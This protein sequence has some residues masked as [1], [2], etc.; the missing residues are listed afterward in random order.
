M[1]IENRLTVKYWH[2][3]AKTIRAKIQEA[4]ERDVVA[5]RGGKLFFMHI[6]KCAGSSFRYALD[7]AYQGCV[8]FDLQHGDVVEA[9][10]EYRDNNIGPDVSVQSL[11]FL[12][13]WKVFSKG[14]P[15]VYG[16]APFYDHIH[17]RFKSEYRFISLVRDPLEK[18]ISWFFY[19]ERNNN[20]SESSPTDDEMILRFGAYLDACGPGMGKVYVQ[21]FCG[22]CIPVSDDEAQDRAQRN[23][24]RFDTI[25]TLEDLGLFTEKVGNLLG[26][27]LEVPRKNAG[28]KSHLYDAILEQYGDRLN[29]FCRQDITLY[30]YI[31]ERC[32]LT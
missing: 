21:Y 6:P 12:E 32:S 8:R 29:E 18:M 19:G 3:R 17:D 11:M 5:K 20:P 10:K 28:A 26:V 2:K 13:T 30:R 4:H 25:G 27:D 15:L 22:T 14:P 9:Y 24:S 7:K 16:H 1:V 23:V 31:K